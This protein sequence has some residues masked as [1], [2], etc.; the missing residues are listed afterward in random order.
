MRGRADGELVEFL[1]RSEDA[2]RQASSSL[3]NDG[4]EVLTLTGARATIRKRS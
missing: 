4:H 2:A 3:K 1:F